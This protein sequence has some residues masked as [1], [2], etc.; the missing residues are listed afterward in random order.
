MHFASI[1]YAFSEKFPLD[2]LLIIPSPYWFNNDLIPLDNKQ[3]PKGLL[4]QIYDTLLC[5]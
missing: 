2:A 5:H 4:T 1:S 3:L